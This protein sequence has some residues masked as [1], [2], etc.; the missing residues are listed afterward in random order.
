MSFTRCCYSH[1][2]RWTAWVFSLL[3]FFVFWLI[4]CPYLFEK[5]C[6]YLR[7]PVLHIGVKERRKVILHTFALLPFLH[8]VKAFRSKDIVCVCSTSRFL[9]ISLHTIWLAI[10]GF[11]FQAP[12]LLFSLNWERPKKE[13]KKREENVH[14]SFPSSS[15]TFAG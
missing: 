5:M 11:F 2:N 9:I 12:L 3:F 7:L 4:C 1:K 8:M 6:G 10:S 13:E 15:M 14:F